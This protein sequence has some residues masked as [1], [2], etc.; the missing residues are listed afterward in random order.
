MRLKLLNNIGFVMIDILLVSSIV[1]IIPI[2]V[3]LVAMKSAKGAECLSNLKNIYIGLQLYESD[4]EKMPD[5]KFYPE[6]ATTDPRSIINI[7][8]RYVDDPR[9]YICPS[10]PD[11]LKKR[12]LTYI[13]NDSYNNNFLDTL[14]NK[15][16]SWVMTDMTIVDI[17]IPPPHQG[18]FNVLFLDGHAEGV[19][20]RIEMTPTPARLKKDI[21]LKYA[22]DKEKEKT[23][24]KSSN[25]KISMYPNCVAL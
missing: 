12:S 21:Y 13:W 10:M 5:A 14:R 1:G 20:E 19:K 24:S 7:L 25:K 11:E 9:V 17:K 18:S 8:G 15:S 22:Q 3:Y 16:S 4:F 23:A 2:S 6:S